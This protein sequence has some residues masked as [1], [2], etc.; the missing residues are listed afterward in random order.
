M[1]IS[2]LYRGLGEEGFRQLLR[3][4]SNPGKLRTY[5]DLRKGFQ[6]AAHLHK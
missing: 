1:E 5:P 3:G 4:I 6:S 2:D